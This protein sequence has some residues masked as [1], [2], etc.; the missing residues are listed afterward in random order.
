MECTAL[1][2]LLDWL[3]EAGFDTTGVERCPDLVCLNCANYA[4]EALQPTAA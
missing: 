3:T 1:N 2:D 4:V